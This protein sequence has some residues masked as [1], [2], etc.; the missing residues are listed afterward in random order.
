[1]SD[2]SKQPYKVPEIEYPPL[3]SINDVTG[4]RMMTKV[5]SKAYLDNY[6]KI[7]RKNKVELEEA[8]TPE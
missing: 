4:E 7:F 3:T 8:E 1:M 2:N 5:P 6:D